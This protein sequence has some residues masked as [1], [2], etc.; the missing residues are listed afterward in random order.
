MSR[1]LVF[2]S[3]KILY[4]F[5]VLVGLICLSNY[6]LHNL[7]ENKSSYFRTPS[8]RRLETT[9][10]LPKVAVYSG[11]FG[12]YRDELQL[13][14]D[15]IPFDTRI[16]YYFFTDDIT[17]IKSRH[18]KVIEHDIAPGDDIMDSYRW[19][20]KSIKFNLPNILN[21]YD[22]I[23]WYDSKVV[24]KPVKSMLDYNEI[25]LKALKHKINF[26]PHP[27]RNTTADEILKT[28]ELEK[29]NEKNGFSFFREIYHENLRLPL[30]DTCF[31]IR[32][33][34]NAVNALFNDAFNTLKE[35]GL[36]RDQ[37]IMS[38]V[39]QKQN[40]PLDDISVSLTKPIP[41]TT[42]KPPAKAKKSKKELV[43]GTPS[44]ALKVQVINL[45]QAI[46]KA[47][48]K[49]NIDEMQSLEESLYNLLQL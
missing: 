14:I 39:V 5:V 21:E 42:Y 4:V 30:V 37:N 48:L 38:Y 16:D 29:E 32:V 17:R 23:V 7:S 33:N 24:N 18:W 20:S 13:G 26:V 31:I 11:N 35:K 46:E 49:G 44:S 10:N 27:D 45:F 41:P 8:L 1:Y 34:D 25:V 28:I 40:F 22:I 36:K 47:A 9:N 3:R 43:L 12:N 2:K 6:N 15:D 19:T